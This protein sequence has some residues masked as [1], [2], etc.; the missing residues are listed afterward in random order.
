L[1]RAKMSKLQQPA[2]SRLVS[3]PGDGDGAEGRHKLHGQC[4]SLRPLKLRALL[5]L[6]LQLGE[7][8]TRERDRGSHRHHQRNG[9][10]L[11][12]PARTRAVSRW[13]WAVVRK[14]IFW[15]SSARVAIYL[16]GQ[17]ETRPTT[18]VLEEPP[19]SRLEPCKQNRIA[20]LQWGSTNDPMRVVEDAA[21]L[22]R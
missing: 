21:P 14:R 11:R 4:I 10:S 7:L 18:A 15:P 9:G 13:S 12:P 22:L 16:E 6:V 19:V 2:F 17:F 20:H 3:I 5:N 1:S 8:I